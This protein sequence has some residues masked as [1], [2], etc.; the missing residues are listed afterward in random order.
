M[1]LTRGQRAFAAQGILGNKTL[2]G[3]GVYRGE[4]VPPAGIPGNTKIAHAKK[5]ACGR[6]DLDDGNVVYECE[7]WFGPE[8]EVP[9][10]KFKHVVSIVHLRA[11][12]TGNAPMGRREKRGKGRNSVLREGEVQ[13]EPGNHLPSGHKRAYETPGVSVWCPTPDEYDLAKNRKRGFGLLEGRRC[14]VEL[15]ISPRGRDK[16]ATATLTKAEL[17][18]LLEYL[19]TVHASMEDAP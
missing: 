11:R 6:I 15:T 13:F 14:V 2:I 17:G 19:N 8:E 16:A 10:L 7:A 3:V 18:E 5:T 1:G 12:A 9:E 4:E